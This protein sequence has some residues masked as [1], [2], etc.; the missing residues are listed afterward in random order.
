MW[1]VLLYTFCHVLL[2]DSE[3]SPKEPASALLWAYY[4][5]AQHYDFLGNTEKALSYIDAAIDH[6]P[7][8]IELFVTKGR[9]Y[10]V[11]IKLTA[12]KIHS[13]KIVFPIKSPC[14]YPIQTGIPGCD[15]M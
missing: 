6:T 7:T 9:V 4:Y 2:A 5:L 1:K 15:T 10:K 8:L 13:T 12:V 11:R 3:N 14:L